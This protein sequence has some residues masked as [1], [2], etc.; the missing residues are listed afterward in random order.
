MNYWRVTMVDGHFSYGKCPIV[1]P[2]SSVQHLLLVFLAL[3][4]MAPGPSNIAASGPS[5]MPHGQLI[6][7][8]VEVDA[9]VMGMS[10]LPQGLAALDGIEVVDTYDN[11]VHVRAP[12]ATLDAISAS[13]HDVRPLMDLHTIS[14]DPVTFDTRGGEPDIPPALRDDRTD[15]YIVQLR[16]PAKDEWKTELS[17]HG[18]ILDI[19][20]YYAFIMRLDRGQAA[21]VSGLD[22]VTW[23]GRYHPYYKIKTGFDE[24]TADQGSGLT[25]KAEVIFY[26]GGGEAYEQGLGAIEGLGGKVLLRD[27]RTGW[28]DDARI[29]FP[30]SALHAIARLD[31]LSFIEPYHDPTSRLDEV[32]WVVQSNDATNQSTPIWDQGLHGEGIV[33]GGSDTGIDLSHSAFRNSSSDVGTPGPSQR[34]VVQYN[35]T[36]DDWDDSSGHGSRTMGIIAGNNVSGFMG[37][38]RYDGIA[39]KAKIAFYDVV[40]PDGTYDPPIMTDILQ[41]AYNYGAESHSDSWGDDTP[42][43][44]SR[45]QRIDQF[46]WD[47]YEFLTFVAPG[48]AGVVWEPATAKDCVS[49]GNTYNGETKD[50]A[51]SS[52]VGPANGNMINPHIVTPGM[53]I[54]APEADLDRNN[55][56]YGYSSGSGTSF[57]TPAAAGATALIEQ[58]FK[59][60]F[61][62]TGTKNPAD[63]FTPSGP[64]K[65]ATLLN[66]GWDQFGGHKGTDAIG[67]SPNNQQGWG[68]VLL[69]DALYFQGDARG[70]WTYDGY[71]NSA[72]HGLATGE[73]STFI[74]HANS[75][76]PFE[77]TLVWNDYPGDGL[78][79]NLDLTVMDPLGN[80]YKGNVYQNG[81]SVLGGIADHFNPEESVQIDVPIEG[82]Y[83]I[84]VTAINIQS[85]VHQRFALVATGS[86]HDATLGGVNF[87]RLVYGM[88]DLVDIRVIDGDVAGTGKAQVEVSS[89]KE[90]TPEPVT[91]IET[92]VKGIFT[93]TFGLSL[94]QP[95]A[96]GKLEV[97]PDDTILVEYLE[98]S[99][100]GTRTATAKVDAKAPVITELRVTDVTTDSVSIRWKTDE[101]STSNVTFGPSIALGLKRLNGSFTT[102]PMLVLNGLLTSTLYYFDVSSSDQ[103]R[104]QA[105]DNNG[106]KHYTFRTAS[107][108]ISAK[109]GY[110]G[111]VRESEGFNHFD[112]GLMYSGYYSNLKRTAVMY[113]NISGIPSNAHFIG[114]TVRVYGRSRVTLAPMVGTWSLE[115]LCGCIDPL[116]KGTTADPGYD[117]IANEQVAAVIGHKANADLVEGQWLAF[118]VPPSTVAMME[119]GLPQGG[120]AFAIIGPDL[121]FD[122]MAQWDSGNIG[123]GNSLGPQY[124]PQMILTVNLRPIVSPGA[125]SNI[126]MDEDTGYKLDLGTVFSDDGPL[127]YTTANAPAHLS[128]NISDAVLNLTPAPN[129][130]GHDAITV[131]AVDRDGLSSEHTIN[132]TVL[133]V[134]DPPH[135]VSVTGR[136]AKSGLLINAT[137]DRT[138]AYPIV[139]TDVDL[140]MEGDILVFG[141]NLSWAKVVN[142][143]LTISPKNANIGVH[144]MLLTVRDLGFLNDSI[145]VV[146]DVVNINDGPVA[147]IS[148]PANGFQG[149]I[150]IPIELNG[151]QSTDPDLPFGD[152]L[153]Y[154][155]SSSVQG[156]L[157]SDPVLN[158]TLK[159]GQ[160]T[161]TLNVTDKAGLKS[162]A[163]INITIYGDCDGDG[164]Y[165][166]EDLDDDNDGMPDYWELAY[167]LDPCDPTDASK[168]PDGDGVTNL[169]EYRA[170][171]NP[172]DSKSHPAKS[173]QAVG[174]W[175]LLA[176]FIAAFLLGGLLVGGSLFLM[177][178]KRQT[179][180]DEPKAKRRV[181]KPAGREEE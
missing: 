141:T 148:E 19:I 39:Y 126:S 29:A 176:V 146:I 5:G 172:A 115:L 73:K 162:S 130:N 4:M 69:D 40:L 34:K 90:T 127:D 122:N 120:L 53:S 161:I 62:P 107:Y 63:G 60:G 174:P 133:S 138:D 10:A 153:D 59:E 50:I 58:Y 118:D 135:L 157:G 66:S 102:A 30:L 144:H 169:Q 43:Y 36:V 80:T 25:V 166:P 61:Y 168:D 32:R 103:V 180:K 6:A 14:F 112:D 179:E 75:T 147:F 1:L 105:I 164:T 11:F 89:M 27:D 99:P 46:Q 21:Q 12:Q 78:K 97:G 86:I 8:D 83:I 123:G 3:L 51:S 23:I 9:L 82:F 33:V 165:D 143:N 177:G 28:W 18:T 152:V 134:N 124:A 178:S 54:I 104:N 37:Y 42:A 113:F 68:K 24:A 170:N 150:G 119:Q 156:D 96:D 15:L 131:R 16:G 94:G 98:T 116:F 26:K 154:R 38:Y 100:A 35:T 95:K 57:S 106:S 139:A 47:H 72:G 173:V 181:A 13:G 129:W 20:Q 56:N 159:A 49:V 84:N 101:P 108:I 132:I 158:R 163:R 55:Y 128:T 121:G 142:R 91:L 93:G 125:P 77:V 71:N 67:H 48:N 145:D 155:W 175:S 70:L 171:T 149:Y 87:D 22:Y 137:Q 85:Q 74:V 160:H 17:A 140:G 92:S 109:A 88:N 79:N 110:A 167:G 64:L 65:K 111:W 45:A 151:S 41:D 136:P 76:L 81:H 7:P 117:D 114:A 2:R 52:A 31:G 44:T